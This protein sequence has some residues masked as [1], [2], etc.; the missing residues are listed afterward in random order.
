MVQSQM[1]L[2]VVQGLLIALRAEML[3]MMA[4]D[5]GGS[6]VCSRAITA[7]KIDVHDV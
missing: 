2:S 4:S 1:L 7:Q 6:G 5:V 3:V